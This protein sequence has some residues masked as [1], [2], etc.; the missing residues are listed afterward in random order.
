MFAALAYDSDSASSESSRGAGGLDGGAC[1]GV[2]A[3][4]GF[5][6]KPGTE[7]HAAAATAHRDAEVPGLEGGTDDG[8]EWERAARKKGAEGGAGGSAART[9]TA[10]LLRAVHGHAADGAP[11]AAPIPAS[12]RV[13]VLIG[14]P[15]SGKSTLSAALA[16]G[17]G[18]GAGG[19]AGWV[20]V[21]QDSLKTRKKCVAAAAR[22]LA[23][24]AR[25]VVDRTNIDAAQ[26]RHWVALAR[27]H[28]LG[29]SAVAAVHLDLPVDVCLRRAMA[30]RDHPTLPG[31]SAKTRA[32]VLRFAAD[33]VAPAYGEGFGRIVT[34][35][36]ARAVAEWVAAQ[37]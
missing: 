18:V 23:R 20:V 36:S 11:T 3:P 4:D 6:A 14:P 2:A 19:A 28:G 35:R 7:E 21:N 10:S 31:G 5:V 12:V 34:L 29:A 24:G 8:R 26:R 37:R 13:L 9:T 30:R 17:A 1:T 22:A 16:G 32:V 25:V 33:A 27:K 15:A